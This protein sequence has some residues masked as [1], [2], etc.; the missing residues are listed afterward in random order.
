MEMKTC[1]LLYEYGRW[2]IDWEYIKKEDQ[3]K[4]VQ[5]GLKLENGEFGWGGKL[6]PR[7]INL[8]RIWSPFQR[9]QRGGVLINYNFLVS[10]RKAI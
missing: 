2:R 9:T 6:W 4:N 1:I 10:K 8:I 3:I 7:C 5:I